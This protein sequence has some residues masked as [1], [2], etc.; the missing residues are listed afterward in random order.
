MLCSK[1]QLNTFH[2]FL[3]PAGCPG[4]REA[5]ADS[6]P[7]LVSPHARELCPEDELPAPYQLLTGPSELTPFLE[8]SEGLSKEQRPPGGWKESSRKL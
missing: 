4:N 2:L 7:F 5:A 8:F 6:P 3:I 1:A